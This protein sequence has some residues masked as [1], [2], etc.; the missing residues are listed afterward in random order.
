MMSGNR[1]MCTCEQHGSGTVTIQTHD[2]LNESLI[3]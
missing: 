3:F 2:L 1:G